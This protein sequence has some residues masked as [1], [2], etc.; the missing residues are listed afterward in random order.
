[1]PLSER[2]DISMLTERYTVDSQVNDTRVKTWQ[3]YLLLL[4]PIP[5]T[6]P[7]I[8]STRPASSHADQAPGG[9]DNWR[10]SRFA[11]G[12]RGNSLVLSWDK[13]EHDIR[14]RLRADGG[15][16]Y[17]FMPTGEED[18]LFIEKLSDASWRRQGGITELS[19][20]LRS[21]L[22]RLSV[23]GR[24]WMHEESPEL[25]FRFEIDNDDRDF[26]LDLE[27]KGVLPGATHTAHTP[28]LAVERHDDPAN[29]LAWASPGFKVH[30]PLVEFF[31][32]NNNDTGL[33][34]FT[35]DITNYR[36]TGEG[37]LWIALLRSASGLKWGGPPLPTPDGFERGR[38]TFDLTLVPQKM[39]PVEQFRFAWAHNSPLAYFP[40][41]LKERSGVVRSE[42][43]PSAKPTR[44]THWWPPSGALRS[45]TALPG[46]L[47]W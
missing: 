24:A 26:R 29:D 9:I 13:Q 35:P 45:R 15:S 5:P 8:L 37:D 23:L 38:S 2:T 42:R 6:S 11:L 44:T 40:L 36:V 31:G 12:V 22:R 18:E 21:S 3:K 4:P 30:F 27:M 14:F 28:Y 20:A 47:A 33:N 39:T 32:L 34:F 17:M 41:K 7:V 25:R 43:P 10:G 1:M 16:Q 19:F 46:W